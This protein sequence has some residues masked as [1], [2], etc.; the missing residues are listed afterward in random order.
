VAPTVGVEVI[1]YGGDFASAP[2][3]HQPVGAVDQ[4]GLAS[5][6]A[7]LLATSIGCGLG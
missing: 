1:V 6:C 7:T 4:R 2:E 3:L 5:V